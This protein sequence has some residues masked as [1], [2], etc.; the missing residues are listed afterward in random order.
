MA[1][2]D[3]HFGAMSFHTAALFVGDAKA[4]DFLQRLKDNGVVVA[5]GNPDVKDRVADGRAD[6]GILDE[7]DAVVAV[8]DH[9]PVAIMITDRDGTDVLGTPLLPNVAVLV[10]GA[11][12]AEEA[13]RFIEFLVS[14]DV[15]GML[16]A[17]DAAQYPWHPNVP[18]PKLL[19][20]FEKVRVMGVDYLEVARRLPVMDAAVRQLL[21]L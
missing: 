2:A 11:P 12:H 14:A 19:P 13:K 4:T 3:P 21:G 15:Q 17:S 18:G 1:I 10:Q 9:R 16:A 7:V 6:V 5:A 8:R 20:A